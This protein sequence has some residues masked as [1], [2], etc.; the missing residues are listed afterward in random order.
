LQRA[1]VTVGLKS[2]QAPDIHQTALMALAE[3][4]QDLLV[5]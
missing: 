1:T 2:Q 3:F 4:R 5:A